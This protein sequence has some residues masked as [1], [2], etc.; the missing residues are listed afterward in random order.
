MRDQVDS[1]VLKKQNYHQRGESIMAQGILPFKYETEKKA[2]G[3]GAGRIAGVSGFSAAD[4]FKQIDS[5]AYKSARRR[6]GVDGYPD[7]V[8]DGVVKPCRR[9]LC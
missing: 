9:R 4:R 2:T 6:P 5:K 8:S 1:M 7:G 3:R